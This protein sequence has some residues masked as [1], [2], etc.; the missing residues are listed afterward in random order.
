MKNIKEEG[1]SI[2]TMTTKEYGKSIGTMTTKSIGSIGT[3]N[4]NIHIVKKKLIN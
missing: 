4:K 1:R 3:M 2:G